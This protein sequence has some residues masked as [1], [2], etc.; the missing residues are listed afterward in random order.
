[1]ISEQTELKLRRL[2]LDGMA[3]AYSGQRSGP[4][5]ATL[6]FDERLAMLVDRQ[7]EHQENLALQR[8]LGYAK[9]RQ[10]A[11]LEDIDWEVPRGLHR[12]LVAQLATG[13]WLRHHRHCLISGPTGVGKSWIACALA[14][15]ACR[16]GYRVLYLSAAKLFRDLLAASSDGSLSRFIRR[17]TRPHLLVVDD[18]GMDTVRRSQYRD[19]LELLEERHDKGSMLIA[20]QLPPEDWHQLVDDPTIA[21]AILDRIVHSAYRISL[22]GE[23]LRQPRGRPGGTPDTAPDAGGPMQPA[24]L[25]S[26]GNHVKQRKG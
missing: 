8:R 19:F 10:T 14:Q 25:T 3:E 13:D 11:A 16:D 23:S 1:M 18:W 4:G 12:E 24:E 5:S 22:D 6:G 26:K 21:D 7:W 15:K 9:L 17:L 2:G 20:S